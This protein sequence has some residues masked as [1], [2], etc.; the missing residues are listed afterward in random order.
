MKHMAILLVLQRPLRFYQSPGTLG[1]GFF[2][3]V[4][5]SEWS[6]KDLEELMVVL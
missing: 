2:M 3:L 4:Q 6:K 1:I 5:L